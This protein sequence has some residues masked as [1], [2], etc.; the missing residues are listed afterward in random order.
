MFSAYLVKGGDSLRKTFHALT[1]LPPTMT[2][3]IPF[4]R[5]A[6]YT[7]NM[8]KR[9]RY[10][11]YPKPGQVEPIAQL[12]GC[13]RVVYNDALAYAQDTYRKTGKKPSTAE[14]SARLT[15]SKKTKERV[16][17]TEV[18]SVPL[19]QSLRDLDKAYKAFFDTVTGKRKGKQSAGAPRFKKRGN[20]Q[21]AR[22]T[23]NAVF[24]VRETT[25]RVG[26]VRLPKIGEV[27]FVLSRP[28]PSEPSSVTLI[29]EPDGAYYVSFVVDV[30]PIP[31][32]HPTAYAVG[33]DM[34]LKH[35][36]ATVNSEGNRTLFANPRPLHQAE[37][38]LAKLQR[39]LSHKK[40]GSHRYERQRIRVAKAYAKVKHTRTH[41][42]HQIANQIVDEN[43]V[44]ALENLMSTDLVRTH[45]GKSI[46]DA[47]WGQL[48]RLIMEKAAERGRRVV[49]AD[50]FAP[51]TQACSVCGASEGKKPL[52]IRT[53]VC[54]HCN[55]RLDRDL[56]ACV[57]IMLA[58]GLAESLNEQKRHVRHL[59]ADAV[60]A[61]TVNP[62]KAAH[63]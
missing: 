26:F 3:H 18:S 48:R 46:M 43:Q 17:L 38:K 12:F 37:K 27:R 14:L 57:N 11:A 47:G 20:R 40:R 31:A 8:L 63:L 51:T 9:Y 4:K 58:A 28:L 6:K 35:L 32:P 52:K 44:I 13:V 61:D 62:L 23:A 39:Q 53:W 54:S 49:F 21:A 50:R 59:L 15:Q 60:V 10:R 7:E 42:L 33:V 45:L 5:S 22:F 24:R 56:N 30:E 16:W 55:T 36:A 34:G 1:G 2:K 41:Y 19:Q 29:R 25:H